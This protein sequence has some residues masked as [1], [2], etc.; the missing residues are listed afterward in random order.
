MA[1]IKCGKYYYKP[2]SII[3]YKYNYIQ[4]NNS[5]LILNTI[6]KRL[7]KIVLVVARY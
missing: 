3:S 2:T 7:S 1:E 5:K 6:F 4:T